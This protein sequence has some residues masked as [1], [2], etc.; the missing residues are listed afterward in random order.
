MTPSTVKVE[1]TLLLENRT[2]ASAHVAG[3]VSWT[4]PIDEFT[5]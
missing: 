4:H 1:Q 5:L 2:T 3:I